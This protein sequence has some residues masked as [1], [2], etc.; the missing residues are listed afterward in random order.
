MANIILLYHSLYIIKFP[1]NPNQAI[2]S[3]IIAVLQRIS[4]LP[5]TTYSIPK[6]HKPIPQTCLIYHTRLVTQP[7]LHFSLEDNT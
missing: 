6:L 2:I 1:I 7:H 3:P 4:D 5:D